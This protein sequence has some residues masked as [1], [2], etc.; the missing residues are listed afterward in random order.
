[1]PLESAAVEASDFCTPLLESAVA[2][3][4]ALCLPLGESGAPA[5]E[6]RVTDAG[7]LGAAADVP[8]DV[9][10]GAFAAMDLPLW[11]AAA[12]AAAGIPKPAGDPAFR[13]SAGRAAFAAAAA[14]IGAGGTA[15]LG[16]GLGVAGSEAPCAGFT[17]LAA[18]SALEV[19]PFA[20]SSVD[21]NWSNPSRSSDS[22]S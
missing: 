6:A 10:A 22:D 21:S 17:S 13:V 12:D 5:L 20:G 15:G 16:G 2:E 11:A 1:M 18:E 7:A 4:N 8:A 9:R 19:L 14:R 3:A